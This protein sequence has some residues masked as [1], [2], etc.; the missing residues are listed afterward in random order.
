MGAKTFECFSSIVLGS[1]IMYTYLLALS[2]LI[3]F[4]SKSSPI[5]DRQTSIWYIYVSAFIFLSVYSPFG[6]YLLNTGNKII[7]NFAIGPNVAAILNSCSYF[8]FIQFHSIDLVIQYMAID[9]CGL[10]VL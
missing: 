2:V 5:V 3:G 9:V 10:E 6:F 8:A 4:Y 1:R 7:E